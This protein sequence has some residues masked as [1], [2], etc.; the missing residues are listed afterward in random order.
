V[1]CDQGGRV[2]VLPLAVGVGFPGVRKLDRVC[3]RVAV[4][5]A[6]VR[7]VPGYVQIEGRGGGPVGGGGGRALAIGGGN[8]GAECV[9]PPVG[10]TGGRGGT[11]AG[12][13]ARLL[14]GTEG[15][16]GAGGWGTGDVTLCDRSRMAALIGSST[17]WKAGQVGKGWTAC[18]I[19]PNWVVMVLI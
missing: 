2:R 16:V 5:G 9:V 1:P 10:G 3:S 13:V 6:R 11:G 19:L 12:R 15:R 4:E 7:V 18:W 8:M 17:P 14:G